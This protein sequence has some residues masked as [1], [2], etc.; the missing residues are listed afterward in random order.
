MPGWLRM[1]EPERSGDGALVIIIGTTRQDRLRRAFTRAGA[2]AEVVPPEAALERASDGADAVVITIGRE[3]A[4]ALCARLKTRF[5]LPLL[6]VVVLLPR[7]ASDRPGPTAP[8]AWIPPRTAPRDVVARVEELVRYRRAQEEMARLNRALAELAA[9]NGR[10]FERARRDSEGT[11]RLLRELQHRVRNNLASI[12]ALLI[13]ERHRTPPRPLHEA[14][15]VAIARLRSMAALQ[16]SLAA[17]SDR[18]EL[19]TLARAVARGA[20]DVFGAAGAV[21]CR[22]TGDASVPSRMG[23]ALA[24]VLNELVT[25]TV[26]HADA[27]ELRIDVHESD[28]EVRLEVVDD[29]CGIPPTA[30][31]GSGLSI[32]RA[33][34]RNELHGDLKVAAAAPGTRVTVRVPQAGTA[35]R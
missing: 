26:K 18:V 11:A 1:E 3:A 13:L 29:G 23:S 24:I 9:E 34:V 20:L 8:D 22:I 35:A 19:G 31:P 14:L 10:L 28:G 27:H 5:Q 32:V 2:R 33:V 16:D 12:Q 25:N 21:E 6:P 17:A 7:R 15:D 4:L 30:P